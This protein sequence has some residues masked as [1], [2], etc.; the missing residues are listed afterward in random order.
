VVL[1]LVGDEA[2]LKYQTVKTEL[3]KLPEVLA[4][5][6]SSDVPYNGFTS[7]GYF[8]EGYKNPLMIHVVD[9]DGDF[10]QAFNLELVKGRNFSPEFGTDKTAYL[11][12]E[13][14]AQTLGWD[15]P[16]G[17]TIVRNGKHQIIGVVKDFHFATLHDRIEP[18]IVTPQPWLDRFENLSVRIK[19][20]NVAETMD[21]IKHV[22]QQAAPFTPFDYWFLDAAFDRLYKSEQR[23]QEIFF[24]F[25]ALAIFIALL[26]LLSLA[27][28][29][30]EQR[31]KEIGIRKVL[32]ASV[33]GIVSLLSKEFVKLVLMA[34]LVAWPL[35]YFAMNQ[36]LQGFAYRINIGW[37]VFALAGAIALLIALITV[38]TQAIKAAL[39]NP[40]EALRYE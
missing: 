31:T 10:L 20:A 38:S 11:I 39:A 9:V 6:A 3:S 5:T 16:I 32:G 1:P 27:A 35:A 4:V 28:F 14:L 34:N 36:W 18:L 25:S 8:P 23:F 15:D 29:F 21:A 7:N 22:W 17:K 24:Y 37:W 30:T 19:S 12:N 2:Q 13:T 40:V 26:G 33:A